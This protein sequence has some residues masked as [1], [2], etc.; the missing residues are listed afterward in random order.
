MGL[1][2]FLFLFSQGWVQD[3]S[4]GWTKDEKVE[5]DSDE[6]E[7]PPLSPAAANETEG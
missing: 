6:D 2:D 4:G 3:G 7:P 1:A 5:F